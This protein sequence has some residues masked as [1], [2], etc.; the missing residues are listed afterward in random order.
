[1]K[2]NFGA[3]VVAVLVLYKKK[4]KNWATTRFQLS[5]KLLVFTFILA[6]SDL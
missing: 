3:V 6:K 4:N 5:G 2:P 1:M